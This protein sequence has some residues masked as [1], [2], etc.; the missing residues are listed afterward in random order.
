AEY[1]VDVFEVR[2]GVIR[3]DMTAGVEEKYDKLFS[4][5]LSLQ[6]RWGEADDVGKAVLALVSGQIPY[7]TGQVL[8]IDGG[9]TIRTM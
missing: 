6:R 2:P 8:K 3:S 7:A 1:G 5:G 9:M 4:E